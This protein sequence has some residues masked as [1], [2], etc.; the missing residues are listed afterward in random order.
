MLVVKQNLAR[1]HTFLKSLV[2]F[3]VS[4]NYQG[5]WLDAVHP[6]HELLS[7]F[8]EVA[9]IFLFDQSDSYNVTSTGA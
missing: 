4:F 8:E 1:A 5:L 2:Q 9:V 6:G 7:N 3:E